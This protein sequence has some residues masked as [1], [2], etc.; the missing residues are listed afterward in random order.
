M[1]FPFLAARRPH[2]DHRDPFTTERHEDRGDH[3]VVQDPDR[4]AATQLGWNDDRFRKGLRSPDL[5]ARVVA[6]EPAAFAREVDD[7]GLDEIARAFADIID[8]KSPWTFRHSEKVALYAR[9][10]G[11]QMGFDERGLR[12]IYRAGLLHDIGKLGV[13]SRILDKNGKL[14]TFERAEIEHHPVHT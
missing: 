14:T 1:D 6:L 8:A 3:A 10:I 11:E 7:E 5:E 2:R 13:S 12:N 4:H 9:A